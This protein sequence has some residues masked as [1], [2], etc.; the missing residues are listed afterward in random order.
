[1]V[2]AAVGPGR[3]AQIAV[4]QSADG[5]RL[6]LPFICLS[7]ATVWAAMDFGAPDYIR[8]G[9]GVGV[10]VVIMLGAFGLGDGVAVGVGVG[11]GTILVGEMGVAVGVGVGVGANSGVGE[12]EGVGVGDWLCAKASDNRGLATPMAASSRQAVTSARM[13]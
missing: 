13:I 9:V 3:F 12:A 6:L 10:G 8:V 5:E 7:A 1:M 11:L 4:A 2:T